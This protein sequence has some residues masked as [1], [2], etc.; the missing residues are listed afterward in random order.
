MLGCWPM[1]CRKR[2]RRHRSCG[3]KRDCPFANEGAREQNHL[4]LRTKQPFARVEFYT[5]QPFAFPA[6]FLEDS[7][8]ETPDTAVKCRGSTNMVAECI[9]SIKNQFRILKSNL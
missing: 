5:A 9:F 4:Y 2:R 3:R 8:K 7:P 1:G 6:L